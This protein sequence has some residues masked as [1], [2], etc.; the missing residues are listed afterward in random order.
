[1]NF[2]LVF[3]LA[4]LIAL[5]TSLLANAN[6]EIQELEARI[7]REFNINVE[8]SRTWGFGEAEY[9]RY[10]NFLQSFIR[11]ANRRGLG[12]RVQPAPVRYVI[13]EVAANN[14]SVVAIDRFE[15][16]RL[17]QHIESN[18]PPEGSPA[19]E[20][21]L[22]RNR[23]VRKAIM[24]RL[25]A[26]KALGFGTIRAS[27]HFSARPAGLDTEE[28]IGYFRQEDLLRG[29]M[30]L[31]NLTHAGRIRYR[32]H[33]AISDTPT[34]EIGLDSLLAWVVE[35]PLNPYYQGPSLNIFHYDNVFN[36]TSNRDLEF[37]I[38]SAAARLEGINRRGRATARDA[39]LTDSTT[40]VKAEPRGT[41]PAPAE[42]TEEIRIRQGQ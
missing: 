22:D 26:L 29:L 13:G 12:R 19:A 27:H 35:N 21:L 1:M 31:E 17:I 16:R 41:G 8:S 2:S 24:D 42:S 14:G 40:P 30:R 7:K 4:G 37:E 32:E 38:A 18:F 11:E 28:D 36:G 3:F 33:I 5:P 39:T 6:N 25:E 10:T 23:S 9:Q 20:R 15:P 34:P